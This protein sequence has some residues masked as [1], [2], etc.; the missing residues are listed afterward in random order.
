MRKNL[1]AVCKVCTNI[2]NIVETERGYPP[3]ICKCKTE[4]ISSSSVT[5]NCKL[6]V[7]V[8]GSEYQKYAEEKKV[9][10]DQKK[11]RGEILDVVIKRE[12]AKSSKL[13]SKIHLVP[14]EDRP[15]LVG[16]KYISIEKYLL[17]KK[18]IFNLNGMTSVKEFVSYYIGTK[19]M[20]YKDMP[21][22]FPKPKLVFSYTVWGDICKSLNIPTKKAGN[23]V[24]WSEKKKAAKEAA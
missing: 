19:K 17:A 11:K 12:A 20:N 10:N 24:G 4:L 22:M 2:F 21:K 15:V 23:P 6:F 1:V 16:K 13:N 5:L 8:P 18:E 14:E 7:D 3:L 9:E